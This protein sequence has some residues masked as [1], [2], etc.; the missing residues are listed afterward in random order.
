MPG[1]LVG[2]VL[3]LG[4][5]MALAIGIA[6]LVVWAVYGFRVGW[7]AGW[8]TPVP[9]PDFLDGLL[10]QLSHA[11]AT[12]HPAFLMGQRSD[13]GWWYYFPVAFALKTP[14]GALIA[15]GFALLSNAWRRFRHAE[16]PL[17]LIP[18]LYMGISLWSVLNIGYRH[19]LPMLPFL[20]VYVGRVGPLLSEATSGSRRRW[21]TVGAAVIGL[22][23]AAG[24]LGV[25]PDYLAYFSELAGGPDG[26]WRY[27]VDSNLDWGQDLPGLKAY[28]DGRLGAR[29][30]LSWFGSTYPYLYG[31]DLQYRLLPSHFSYPYS[32]DAAQSPY[33][34]LHPEPA[35]YAIS[36]TNLQ[37]VGLAEG[38]LFAPFRELS[39]VARIGHSIMVYDLTSA[40]W[41]HEPT[42]ISGLSLEDLTAETAALS[43]G[44]APG[45]VKWFDHESSFV[46]P[47]VGDPVYVL[48]GLPLPFA[49]AWQADL[50]QRTVV[51]HEQAAVGRT[52]AA[53]VYRLDRG[54]AD[55]WL[56]SATASLTLTPSVHLEY[57]LDLVGYRLPS[58]N[59]PKPGQVLELIT[60]WQPSDEMPAAATDLKVFVHLLDASG[61]WRA[62][63][64]AFGL[65]APTWEGGDWLFQ[66]HRVE[67]PADIASGRYSLEVGLYSPITAR[68][69]MVWSPDGA[70]SDHLELG[71]VE[72]SAP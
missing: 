56:A 22:W 9:A 47:G 4:I 43:L 24:T 50:L 14:L 71:S 35:L 31:L 26:G 48:T 1:G 69:L 41:G 38:D 42:C 7:V 64:D 58:G 29:V 55:Q 54:A 66:Y 45:P 34:P 16:W 65:H 68:R 32:S 62:G 13:K 70:S 60:A 15:M 46:L 6:A 2:R 28:L 72:I 11:S 23:L 44:R 17:L 33:N 19:L 51:I 37:G 10:G 67:I 53:V 20:W 18:A 3:G 27:L 30:Y 8:P 61:Q 49:P 25:A 12:G 39:P 36:A 59:T 40:P 5:A 57:G 63:Q 21:L 52:P